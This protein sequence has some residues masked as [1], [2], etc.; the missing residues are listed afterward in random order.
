MTSFL[1]TRP[2]RPVPAICARSRLCSAA[3]RATTGLI[4]LRPPGRSFSL[5]LRAAAISSPAAAFTATLS[6]TRAP[7]FASTSRTLRLTSTLPAASAGGWAAACSAALPMIAST[8]PALTVAPAATRISSRTPSAGAG[9]SV[10]ILSVEISS[11]ASFFATRSPAPF[12]QR[13]TVPSTT[14]SPSCGILTI[15]DI[16]PSLAIPNLHVSPRQVWQMSETDALC[17]QRRRHICTHVQIILAGHS[18]ESCMFSPRRE[19]NNV[20]ILLFTAG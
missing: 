18:G 9:T 15:V 14:L 10:S 12:S 17:Q 13:A 19:G 20:H 5:S 2:R 6:V 1:V 7:F 3:M 4:K 11:S 8:A 16:G